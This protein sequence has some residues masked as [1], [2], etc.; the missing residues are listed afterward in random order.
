MDSE[1]NFSDE[2]QYEYEEDDA[3]VSSGGEK[4]EAMDIV[5]VVI[6]RPPLDSASAKSILRHVVATVVAKTGSRWGTC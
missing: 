5:D 4:D 6:E 2:Y 3:S 1:G